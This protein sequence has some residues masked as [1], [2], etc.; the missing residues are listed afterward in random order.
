MGKSNDCKWM[1]QLGKSSNYSWGMFPA[2]RGAD[3]SGVYVQL[4]KNQQ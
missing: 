1:L 3:D 2:G 4:N